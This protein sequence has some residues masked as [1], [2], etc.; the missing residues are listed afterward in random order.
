MHFL[1]LISCKI[2]QQKNQQ[3]YKLLAYQVTLQQRH[4]I[5]ENI[6][7]LKILLPEILVFSLVSPIGPAETLIQYV[8]TKTTGPISMFFTTYN[9]T[10]IIM[11]VYYIFGNYKRTRISPLT[12]ISKYGKL[13]ASPLGTGL[14]TYMSQDKYF[15]DLQN[16]WN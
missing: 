14:P 9:L 5:V 6:K 4:Q 13:I 16:Q 3:M 11:T 1:T 15:K 7:V 12:N 10:A 2:L 8:L